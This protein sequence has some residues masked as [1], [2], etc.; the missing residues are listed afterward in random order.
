VAATICVWGIVA[1]LAGLIWLGS[2]EPYLGLPLT[3]PMNLSL[4]GLCGMIG[5]GFTLAIWWQRP[6]T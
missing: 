2:R 3:H 5:L 4:L 6:K 1:G